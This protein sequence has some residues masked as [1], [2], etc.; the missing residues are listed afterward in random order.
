M[1]CN[2]RVTTEELVFFG[3][4]VVGRYFGPNA[5]QPVSTTQ[6]A[7]L[8]WHPVFANAF[9]GDMPSNG[10]ILATFVFCTPKLLLL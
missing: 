3:N 10:N 6:W 8:V 9:W 4:V 5:A 2:E 7:G 1:M